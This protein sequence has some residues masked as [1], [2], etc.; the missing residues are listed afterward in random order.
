M[1]GP[2]SCAGRCERIVAVTEERP[3]GWSVWWLAM[4]PKT[5]WAGVAPVAIGSCLAWRD[6]G[7]HAPTALV[8]L[9]GAMSVQVGTNLANDYSDF[10]RGADADDRIG[11]VRV[12]Q[13][14]LLAPGTVFRAAAAA[15]LVTVLCAAVAA[16]RGGWPI[17]M[18]AAVGISCGILYTAGPVPLGYVGLGDPLVFLFFGPGAVG[19]TYWLQA[20]SV[21]SGVLVIGAAP[22]LLSVAMLAVNNLRDLDTDRRA[23]KHTLAVRFGRRFARAEV[24]GCVVVAGLLPGLVAAVEG[25]RYATASAALMLVP[26]VPLFRTICTRTDGPALNAALAAT[27]RLMLLFTALFCVTLGVAR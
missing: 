24:I 6:G 4:R 3:S 19:A 1:S 14:G 8:C 9:L 17:V 27:G 23:G 22:G 2:R 15:F 25:R 26:A 7:A 11:P 16:A 12:T 21:P 18:L 10:Q 5:L 13:A 20:G